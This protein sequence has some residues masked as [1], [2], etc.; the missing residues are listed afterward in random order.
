MDDQREH[1]EITKEITSRH[2]FQALT[3]KVTNYFNGNK[4][5]ICD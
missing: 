5:Q 2:Q 3:I 4:S 1:Y